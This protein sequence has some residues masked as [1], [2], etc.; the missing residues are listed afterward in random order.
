MNPKSKD[1]LISTAQNWVKQMHRTK[2]DLYE[3]NNSPYAAVFKPVDEDNIE[4]MYD[5]LRRYRKELKDNLHGAVRMA[6]TIYSYDE[7]FDV[8]EQAIGLYMLK[9]TE[10]YDMSQ[11]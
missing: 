4:A 1:L 8:L 7:V 9:Q 3:C 2:E 10:L 6:E 5:S 11:W